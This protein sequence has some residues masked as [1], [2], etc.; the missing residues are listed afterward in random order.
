MKTKETAKVKEKSFSTIN[1]RSFITV[2][3][4]LFAILLASG[5]ISYF[6]PQGSFERDEDGMIINGSYEQGE[7][8]GIAPWRVLTAPFRVFASDDALTI[9]MISIFLLIMSGVFN[10]IEK[11]GGI[12]VILG[13]TVRSFS[14]KTNLVVCITLL[15]FML[16][17]SFFG[18]FEELVTLL[19]LVVVFMLSMKLDTLTGVGIC[20]L[21]A[22]FGFSAA[23]TNP[24]SV[25]L[26][27]SIAGTYVL[28]GAWLRIVFFAVVYILVG[29]FLLAHVAKIKKDPQ[30]SLTYAIDNEKRATL[31]LDSYE[32]SEGDKKIFKVFV[33]FFAVQLVLLI[34]IAS[35]RAISGLAI[36]LLSVSFLVGGII[37]GLLVTDKKSKVASY[38]LSGALSMLPAV[39]LIALAS[40][41]KLVMTESGILD[42][43][44]SGVIDFLDGKNKFI[45]II[46]V[47]ALIL[48]LQIFIGSA[49]AKI[50]LIMP[51]ILP[52][53]SALGI[54]PNVVILTYCIADG[55]TDMIMPTNPVLLIGLSMANVSYGKWVR[56]TWKLQLIIFALTVGLLLLAVQ[57]GY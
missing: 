18:M 13:K 16:F 3:I 38:M 19:P 28:D 30:K 4:L 25:G 43:L 31:S 39:V 11:T 26:A 5:A 2:L 29:G 10:L 33:I 27:S 24:F 36:P 52:I 15:F 17:G 34:L 44:M 21:G 57:I 9:I 53:C 42:T 50:I 51:I 45:S 40:S 35:V 8:N 47:Y 41:V 12:R 1:T 37:S 22:C 14:S 6:V 49:S 48:F 56:W 55:F 7:V 32:E 20:M 23:I 54:S 46:L